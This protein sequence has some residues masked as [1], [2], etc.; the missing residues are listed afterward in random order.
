VIVIV[1]LAIIAGFLLGFMAASILAANRMAK[2]ETEITYLEQH[3]DKPS[4][5]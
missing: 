2:L 1:I 4:D 5:Q 3:D